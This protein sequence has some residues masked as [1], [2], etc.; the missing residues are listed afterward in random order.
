MHADPMEFSSLNVTDYGDSLW[1]RYFDQIIEPGF[2][3]EL[4]SNMMKLYS[5]YYNYTLAMNETTRKAFVTGMLTEL[6]SI[7]IKTIELDQ[8]GELFDNDRLK[9]FFYS[10]HDDSTVSLCDAFEYSLPNYPPFAS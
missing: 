10:D 4:L 1:A 2:D 9:L 7:F 8:K 6:A 3:I 5:E